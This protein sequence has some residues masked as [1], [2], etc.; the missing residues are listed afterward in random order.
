MHDSC[1][2]M[3]HDDSLMSMYALSLL[4]FLQVSV[5]IRATNA[6]VLAE[7]FADVDQ[8]VSS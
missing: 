4:P 1:L 7:Q 8:T 2:M 3:I 5:D 6:G